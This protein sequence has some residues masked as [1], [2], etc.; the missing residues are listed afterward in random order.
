MRRQ[1]CHHYALF[2][3]KLSQNDLLKYMECS[4]V[5]VMFSI[6]VETNPFSILV[7]KV[8]FY[9]MCLKRRLS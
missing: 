6:R 4:C 8:W 1:M 3:E 5:R 9:D 2:L 7:L